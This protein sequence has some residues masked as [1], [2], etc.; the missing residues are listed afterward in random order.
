MVVDA[1]FVVLLFC[2]VVTVGFAVVETGSVV[3]DGSSLVHAIML[4]AITA[5]RSAEISVFVNFIS[6]SPFDYVI[7]VLFYTKAFI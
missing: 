3:V 5:A 7:F 6:K 2:A 4:A 1:L